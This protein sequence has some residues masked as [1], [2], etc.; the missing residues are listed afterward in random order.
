[1]SYQKAG[2]TPV[3]LPK[4][5]WAKESEV[6]ALPERLQKDYE[7][8]AERNCYFV[9]D[10]IWAKNWRKHG[11]YYYD[12]KNPQYVDVAIGGS[13]IAVGYDGSQ[14]EKDMILN[15]Y[16][17]QHGS[18]FHC[19]ADVVYQKAGN[20]FA[21]KEPS[22]DFLYVG[23][24]EEDSIRKR[25]KKSYQAAHPEDVVEVI[26]DTHMYQCGERDQTGN[27]KYPFILCD[28][29][30]VVVINGEKGVLEC[31]TCTKGSPDY[32]LWKQGKV[33][34]K[35]Y[36][37][38]CYYMLCMNYSY[39]Y[40]CC[41]WGISADEF[42]YVRIERNEDVENGIIAIA[43]ELA[44][45]IRQNRIPDMTGQNP[46]LVAKFWL[47][48]MGPYEPEAKPVKLSQNETDVALEL[49]ALLE[50]EALLNEKLNNIKKRCFE[51]LAKYVFPKVGKASKAFVPL[52]AQTYVEL[53][54]KNTTSSLEIDEDRLKAELPETY[55]RYLVKKFNASAFKKENPLLVKQYAKNE[56]TKEK[57]NYL[58]MSYVPTISVEAQIS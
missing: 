37:Q 53:K 31:K 26:N 10:Y 54:F 16:P 40:I 27:L 2:V 33:P 44:E 28:L 12:T 22:N 34:L 8:D 47:K 4:I 49:I 43:E 57:V 18:N 17:K 23:H 50:E 58:K 36:L 29:D 1:M 20:E 45:A 41:K 15:L 39:A 25:F 6:K 48:V 35:Y 11:P 13:D 46:E 52:D 42:C 24:L 21:L 3:Q 30:G 56:L 51:L 38:V 32:G 9:P 5:D 14:M 55:E 7:Y 19:K